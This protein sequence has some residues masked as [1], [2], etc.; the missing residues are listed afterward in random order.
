M[1]NEEVLFQLG[2]LEKGYLNHKKCITSL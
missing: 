1:D 2:G